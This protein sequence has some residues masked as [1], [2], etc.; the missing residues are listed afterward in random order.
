MHAPLRVGWQQL[1]SAMTPVRTAR[2]WTT[3]DT[4]IPIQESCCSVQDNKDA[5]RGT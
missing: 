1:L 2:W 5:Y 3:P 4:V